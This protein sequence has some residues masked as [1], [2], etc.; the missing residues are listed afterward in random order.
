MAHYNLHRVEDALVK[1]KASARTAAREPATPADA[2]KEQ[3]VNIY[4]HKPSQRYRVSQRRKGSWVYHGSCKTLPEAQRLAG[5]VGLS[6]PPE[7]AD[8]AVQL[9]KCEISQAL[10]RYRVLSEVYAGILPADL[11]D[12]GDRLGMWL[13]QQ[14]PSGGSGLPVGPWLW[15]GGTSVWAPVLLGAQLR[16]PVRGF[17]AYMDAPLV[18]VFAALL[19]YGPLRDKLQDSLSDLGNEDRIALRGA[20]PD[21]LHQVLAAT[22]RSS[23][24]VE[25]GLWRR[26]ANRGRVARIHGV[27]FVRRLGLLRKVSVEMLGAESSEV[28]LLDG[29]HF[30]LKEFCAALWHRLSMLGSLQ[31][32]V[33]VF[34]RSP[35][36]A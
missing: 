11:Q 3:A 26:N 13:D 19:K 32:V 27:G 10:T 28:L 4:W 15:F 18:L 20:D 34:L 12:L 2:R 25:V 33:S 23:A 9:P 5:S 36:G 1:V 7:E 17:P 8:A 22:M 30:I 6:A 14:V 31:V 35:S 16:V 29:Q 24:G 21:A